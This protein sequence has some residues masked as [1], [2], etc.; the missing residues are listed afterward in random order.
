MFNYNA[1]NENPRLLALFPVPC[2][3]SWRE[4][5]R[6][7]RVNAS[8]LDVDGRVGGE[9]ISGGFLL[10]ALAEDGSGGMTLNDR[11][12]EVV[13]GRSPAQAGDGSRGDVLVIAEGG[14]SDYRIV[15]SKSASPSELHGAEELR[16]FLE[17]ICAALLPITTDEEPLGE[18]EII[19]G[20]NTHLEEA[21]ID[22]D[23]QG[24]G[25]EGFVIQ[26]HSPHLVIVG[27]R[28][29]GTMYGV[30]AF[31]EEYLG[32]R[33]FTSSVSR[34]PHL[35]RLAI[36]PID[37]R[38]V[39]VLEYRDVFFL[40]AR[41]P[42]WAA[43]NRVNGTWTLPDDYGGKVEFYP[44]GHSFWRLIPPDRYFESHPEWFSLVD[45]ERT[46][47]GRYKR[48]QLCLTNEEM[49]Q[50]AIRT[51][52]QWIRENP[53]AKIFSV[54]QNDGP[55]GWCEC[56]RCA[57]LEEREGGAHSAPIIYF[58]N[59]IADAI[60]DEYP[61]VL[62]DTFAYSYSRKA[63]NSLKPRPNVVIR[64]TT[65]ACCSHEIEDEKCPENASLRAAI[66]DW[67]R[68]T[69]RIYV[70]DYIVNFRQYL[71]PFPNLHTIGP[72]IRFLVRN[73]VRG[74]F[75]QG[76]GDVLA[77]DMA[78]LKAY[79]TAKL[80]WDPDYDE[81]RAVDEFLAGYYGD[82]AGMMR[83]YL[84][85]LRAEVK[86][87]DYHSLHVKPF[88][89]SRCPPY[90]TSQVMARA[91][92]LLER[93]ERQVAD[94]GELLLRVRTARLSIDYVKLAMAARVMATVDAEESGLSV[95]D[96]YRSAMERFFST[97]EEAGIAHWRESSRPNSTMDELREELE[98]AEGWKA[99]GE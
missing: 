20:V 25:D 92:S 81:E 51:V 59:R 99:D 19:L 68:L 57:A 18:H 56:E 54:S 80:L 87:Q 21:G 33:W 38:Q 42:D 77:S 3:E 1:A 58:V 74:L 78:P 49:I 48:T 14:E 13:S 4:D 45:G 32:C 66:A 11:K 89:P 71:M 98:S 43:R 90:L 47:K 53:Q 17:E 6:V 73:G 24:L 34:I 46:L 55:G 16:T 30:Y 65:G 63:P 64:L 12:A 84:D 93:A 44:F 2:L 69:D 36:G 23:T 94:D 29:R 72:N 31:L 37:D 88:E 41:D 5:S 95:E 82:A 97:A 76:S 50:Q 52:K 61:D 62:I 83:E 10:G 8:G 67:F 75:E 39:P 91:T 9:H 22:V 40:D 86:G 96:W 35:S 28:K 85:M 7:Y 70:W 79:L 60:A 15:V 26:T 27:G